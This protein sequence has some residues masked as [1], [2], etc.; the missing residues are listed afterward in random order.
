LPEETLEQGHGGI[1]FVDAFCGVSGDMFISGLLD[2]GV[3]FSVLQKTMDAL[4]IDGFRM[5]RGTRTRHGVVASSFDVHLD[6][7]QGERHWS[8][9][10]AMIASAELPHSVISKARE[11]FR[12][13]AEAES[14]VHGVPV[15]DVHFHEVGAVDAIVDIVGA[16]ALVSYLAPS[17]IVCSPWPIGHGTVHARHGVLPLPAP[18][19]VACLRGVPTYGVDV[20]GELVTPTGAAIVATLADEFAHW[21][22]MVVDRM[23]FGSGSMQWKT[24]PNL[25][26]VVLGSR[27][28]C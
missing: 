15:C 24:R 26:R 27:G 20:E 25:L 14:H 22:A 2:V 4:P 11:I 1:L 21:P 9:I 12:R 6:G 5:E 18:A 16:A 7:A 23:G 13:L 28:A 10:D 8:E 17:R 3:P 19:T